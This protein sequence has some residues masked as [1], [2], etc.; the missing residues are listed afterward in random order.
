MLSAG[1]ALFAAHGVDAARTRD[2]VHLAGQANDSAVTY[3]FGSRR[4]LLEAILRAGVDRMEA[5]RSADLAGLADADLRAV[6][7]AVVEPIAAEL[8]TTQGR[9]FLRI[10][11]QVAGHAGVR[12]GSLPRLIHHTAL[13]AEL[14]LLN[15]RC[16]AF[17]PEPLA[18]ERIAA[19]IS[20]LTTA[21]ADRAART[22]HLLDQPA[23]TANLVAM[24]TAALSA[25]VPE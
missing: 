2:I 23:F 19:T 13:A 25:P 5:T 6:V 9:D 18:R 14:D 1:A 16:R 17:L 11:V 4:G 8:H 7:A 12:A 22:D 15:E 20:F 21:L 24:L 3:H 10:V